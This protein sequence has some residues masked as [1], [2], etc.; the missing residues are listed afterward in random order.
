MDFNELLNNYRSFVKGATFDVSHLSLREMQTLVFEDMN[1]QLASQAIAGRNSTQNGSV[2]PTQQL[3]LNQTEIQQNAGNPS[4]KVTVPDEQ[5]K[6]SIEQVIGVD[7]GQ[8]PQQSLVVT[9]DNTN[10][11]QVQVHSIADVQPVNEDGI[12]INVDDSHEYQPKEV[13]VCDTEESNDE[14]LN[15]ILSFCAKVQE[16]K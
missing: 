1:S 13:H 5:G 3:K 10:Q 11:N 15:D 14:V 8:N 2:D 12:D 4:Y 7:I 9:K 16:R 6:S